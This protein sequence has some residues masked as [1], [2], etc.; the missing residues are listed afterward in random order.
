MQ[1]I[2]LDQNKGGC[3]HMVDIEV[4]VVNNQGE[5]VAQNGYEQG[6][7]IVKGHGVPDD[8]IENGNHTNIDGWLRTGDQ[9]T[10]DED[11]K[12]NIIKPNKDLTNNNGEKVSAFE[13]EN[14]LSEHPAIREIV[15]IATPDAN[16][17]EVLHAFIVLHDNNELTEQELITF[18]KKHFTRPNCPKKVTFMDELPKTTSGKILRTQLAK[19]N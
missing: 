18:A 19:L 11:G 2:I 9:G 17:G 14:V 15:L 6:E 10:I 7:I 3:V 12:I 4:R 5:D 1:S 16:L 13:I 8:N